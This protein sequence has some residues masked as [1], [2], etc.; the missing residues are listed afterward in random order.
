MT[1]ITLSWPDPEDAAEFADLCAR[2]RR[3]GWLPDPSRDALVEL[4][5]TSLTATDPGGPADDSAP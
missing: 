3:D 1:A 2:L 4:A 5:R